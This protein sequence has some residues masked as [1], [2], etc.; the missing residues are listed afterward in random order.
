MT[1]ST[2]S[3]VRWDD[4]ALQLRAAR[5]AADTGD[6]RAHG[7]LMTVFASIEERYAAA[8]EA[9]E[10]GSTEPLQRLQMEALEVK[11]RLHTR[12]ELVDL[13]AAIDAFKGSAS[14][15]QSLGLMENWALRTMDWTRLQIMRDPKHPDA[16]QAFVDGSHAAAYFERHWRDEEA[17]RYG[18]MMAAMGGYLYA[19]GYFRIGRQKIKYGKKFL[20]GVHEKKQYRADLIGMYRL[21]GQRTRARLLRPLF[22]VTDIVGEIW[23]A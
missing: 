8:D 12:G 7:D 21:A 23:F 9:L 14:I 4:L 6:S 18:K 2:Q 19:H 13:F 22:A 16:E 15:A 3:S 20:K 17:G 1:T 10:D 11:G 5:I